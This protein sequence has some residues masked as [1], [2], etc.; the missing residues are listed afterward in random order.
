MKYHQLQNNACTMSQPMYTFSI[1]TSDC[2]DQHDNYSNRT[3]SGCCNMLRKHRLFIALAGFM[4]VMIYI[5]HSLLAQFS[6]D[7]IKVPHVGG[8][9][10]TNTTRIKGKIRRSF[11]KII[12]LRELLSV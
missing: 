5:L 10:G 2:D 1:L 6:K 8:I 7:T 12:E 3:P 4:V 9:K 11:H